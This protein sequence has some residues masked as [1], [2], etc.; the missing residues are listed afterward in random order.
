MTKRL[1]TEPIPP[2]RVLR[3]IYRHY[4][5][6]RDYVGSYGKHVIDHG[7]WI[8]NEDGT[9]KAKIPV[10]ISF[11]DLHGKLNTLSGRKKEA[12]FYN[13]ILDWRQKDVAERMGITTVSVGQYVEQAMTQLAESY[14][15]EMFEPVE[16]K[17]SEIGKQ[18][19]SESKVLRPFVNLTEVQSTPE[20][21]A[22]S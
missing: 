3:E 6:Y 9:K 8:Y 4:L 2:H 11:W 17:S 7:Y 5:E 12:V 20:P 19:S 18:R 13:V 15:S 22:V 1:Q 10:T 14:F 21:H 16:V